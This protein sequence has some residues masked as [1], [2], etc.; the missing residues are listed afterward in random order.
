MTALIFMV[1]F[2]VVAFFIAFFIGRDESDKK[3]L[4]EIEK[5]GFSEKDI[6]L[7]D[8]LETIVGDKKS[9]NILY[10]KNKGG[11]KLYTFPAEK[12][13]RWYEHEKKV[14]KETQY[15]ITLVLDVEDIG[16]ATFCSFDRKGIANA[17]NFIDLFRNNSDN[18][19]SEVR[20]QD[21]P[22]DHCV[23]NQKGLVFGSVSA[24]VVV[25]IFSFFGVLSSDKEPDFSESYGGVPVSEYWDVVNACQT[26]RKLAKQRFTETEKRFVYQ[27]KC[28]V[29]KLT[30][31]LPGRYS[32]SQPYAATWENGIA[33]RIFENVKGD[34]V[35]LGISKDG[36]SFS[37]NSNHSPLE[38]TLE[39][40]ETECKK[41]FVSRVNARAVAV[42][43]SKKY[44]DHSGGKVEIT[45]TGESDMK[46][47]G[48]CLYDTKGMVMATSKVPSDEFGKSVYDRP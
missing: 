35:L 16:E 24:L 7:S 11:L 21:F 38:V 15:C 34:L 5:L 41:L 23:D 47:Q 26:A 30:A 27:E 48:S 43:E 20:R 44:D 14:E 6:I 29:V 42:V 25:A 1:S 45:Y 17:S 22:P 12:I 8:N 4:N 40:L 33:L 36:I 9:G 37:W 10:F 18:G 19:D 46:T 32:Y 3:I 31:A 39:S 28:T 2:S 13:S